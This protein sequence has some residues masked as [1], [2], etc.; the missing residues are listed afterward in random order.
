MSANILQ[1]IGN[2]SLVRLNRV[3]PEGCG[4]IFVKAEWENPTGSMKDRMALAVISRAEADGRLR[5]GGTVVEYTGGS[6]GASLAL[7]CAAKG[8]PIHVVSARAF[9][10]EKLDHMVAYG[11]R[12]TLVPYEGG[13]FTKQLFL[14]MIETARKLSLAPN[15]YFTDQLNNTDSVAGYASLGDEIWQQMDGKVDAFVHSIGT[16]ASLRGVATVLRRHNPKVRIV[17]VEPGESPVL[18]GGKP[19]AHDIEGIGIGYAPPLW[20]AKLA[21]QV[22]AVNT[23]DA[24]DMARRLAREEGIFAGTS[25]GGNVQA[26][27]RVAR[28]LGPS[29]RIATL[30]I[31][32]GLKY[33]STDLYR[34]E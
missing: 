32:S 3:V 29:A 9:S 1:S 25:S 26:A 21:D 5:P 30:M 4:Q 13:G 7:V 16:G 33:V 23:A 34:N 17:A 2:T 8:Y 22:L 31:D 15:T 18:S 14:D 20:D 19:G 6:T 10:Q 24:K 28:E 27:I 12:L 11:A